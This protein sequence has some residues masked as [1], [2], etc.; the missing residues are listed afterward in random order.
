[1]FKWEI[2]P[3]DSP[4]ELEEE[5]RPFA[6][7]C[8]AHNIQGLGS[9]DLSGEPSPRLSQK[10]SAPSLTSLSDIVSPNNFFKRPLPRVTNGTENSMLGR[11]F[12]S[13][14]ALDVQG[15]FRPRLSLF[16][17]VSADETSDDLGDSALQGRTVL[18]LLDLQASPVTCSTSYP[19]D[20]WSWSDSHDLLVGSQGGVSEP[21]SEPGLDYPPTTKPQSMPGMKSAPTP[22]ALRSP[23]TT[24]CRIVSCN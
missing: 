14:N 19:E 1:M 22:S 16:L 17:D 9:T 6:H 8:S 15:S 3:D 10:T 24:P 21:S 5:L 2:A 4:G 18:E 13:N 12:S 20:G 23:D 11:C 7:F